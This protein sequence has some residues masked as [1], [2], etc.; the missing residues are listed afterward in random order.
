MEGCCCLGGDAAAAVVPVQVCIA[1]HVCA[2]LTGSAR[3]LLRLL[4]DVRTYEGAAVLLSLMGAA[5]AAPPPQPHHAGHSSPT[6]DQR[7]TVAGAESQSDAQPPK[8]E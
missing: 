1:T 6:S 8:R 5:I 7:S 3:A 4:H 2:T